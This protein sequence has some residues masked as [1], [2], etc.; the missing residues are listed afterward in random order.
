MLSEHLVWCVCVC[1]IMAEVHNSNTTCYGGL[2]LWKS[3]ILWLNFVAK[4]SWKLVQC[5]T[6]K[7]FC[8]HLPL[9]W[10][11]TVIM[12]LNFKMYEIQGVF[13]SAGTR[14]SMLNGKKFIYSILTVRV[15]SSRICS[16]ICRYH[17]KSS[18]PW[19][20][21]KCPNWKNLLQISKII[22]GTNVIFT[23]IWYKNVCANSVAM[24]RAFS[25]K[26]LGSNLPSLLINLT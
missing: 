19:S 12:W 23:I 21:V 17:E 10:L 7:L 5:R 20:Q 26:M 11:F 18:C 8:R 9:G 6:K 3:F 25:L 16:R 13:V 2:T 24:F 22:L 15:Q 4:M 14:Y 1:P